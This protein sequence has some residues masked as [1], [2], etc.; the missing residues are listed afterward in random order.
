[1]SKETWTPLPG[2]SSNFSRFVTSKT[3][4]KIFTTIEIYVKTQYVQLTSLTSPE[5]FKQMLFLCLWHFGSLHKGE[6]SKNLSNRPNKENCGSSLKYII[7][8][9]GV[10]GAVLQT[11]LLLIK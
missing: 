1:M 10:A 6:F 7:N 9:P 4:Y 2:Q 5:C 3:D 8:R 11:P